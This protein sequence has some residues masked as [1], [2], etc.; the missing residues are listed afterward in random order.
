MGPKSLARGALIGA[1]Y[2]LISLAVAPIGSGLLQ[3]RLSEALCVL[4]WFT[5]AA[6]PGLF[7]GCLLANLLT[8]A[9]IYDVVFGSLATGLAAL[10]TFW[11]RRRGYSKWLA[12]LPAVVVN[13]LVVGY[14]LA[15]VYEVGVS[16]ALCALSVAAGQILSCY[17]LGMPLMRLLEKH[18]EMFE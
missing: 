6:I 12:P 18:L 15:Y 5:P 9:V 8:G 14:L 3:A 7:L 1:L 16:M 17:G 4:P 10:L 11:F 13:A 2:V